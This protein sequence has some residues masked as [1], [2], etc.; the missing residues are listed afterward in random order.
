MIKITKKAFLLIIVFTFSLIAVSQTTQ[1]ENVS[2]INNNPTT[3]APT[4]PARETLDVIS[5]FSDTYNNIS[6]ANYNP[7]WDQSGFGS[8]NL[9][10][11]PT[12]SGNEVL[13]YTNFNY[14]GIEFNSEQDL[15]AMEFL[16]IDIWTVDVATP[17]IFVISSGAEIPHTMTNANGLWKSVEIPIAGITGDITKA[18][19][20]KFIGGNGYS[21]DIYL[22]NIYFWKS[23]SLSTNN[24]EILNL[25]AFP[26]PSKNS[27]TVKTDGENI[28]SI[29]VFDLQSKNVFSSTP[30]TI[31]TIIEGS[32]LKGGFYLAQIK[33]ESG[34]KTIKLIKE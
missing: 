28:L 12:G 26:N 14:Q 20:L 9:T 15:T 31:T 27:W 11:Q 19:Q 4:P 5:I 29:I 2:R 23:A 21:N 22:D 13:A 1:V 34:V 16:H 32:N 6:G 33:T 8:A 18:I 25:K 24:V 3:N 7:F 30:N 10:F 17:R